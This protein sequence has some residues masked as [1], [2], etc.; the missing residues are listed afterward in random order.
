M[1]NLAQGAADLLGEEPEMEEE[2][3]V[4]EEPAREAVEQEEAPYDAPQSEMLAGLARALHDPDDMVRRRARPRDAVR[5][6]SRL[7]SRARRRAGGPGGRSGRGRGTHRGRPRG[8]GAGDGLRTRGSGLVRA[9]ALLVPDGAPSDG[10]AG[11]R[12]GP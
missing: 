5:V 12:G 7:A 9:R 11:P 10:G 3:L 8:P 1:R 6:G 2:T 4:E